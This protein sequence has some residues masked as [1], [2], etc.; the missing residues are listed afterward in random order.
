[1][2]QLLIV[3]GHSAI[4]GIEPLRLL[5]Q[6]PKR[7]LARHELVKLLRDIGDR[8][9]WK[10]VVVF[11]GAQ[12]ERG[13][14]G[15]TEDGIL[16]IYSRARETADSVIERLAARFVEKGDRV[17]VASDDGMVLLTATTFGAEGMRIAELEAW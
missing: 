12:T 16:V 5:H 17:R 3:D 6:G 1:M 10:V 4:F 11:D 15:G 14:E 13:Y 8:G 9:E 2:E 7:Y